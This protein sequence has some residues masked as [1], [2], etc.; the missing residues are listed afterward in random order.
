MAVPGAFGIYHRK[1]AIFAN[2]QTT[3]L[4]AVRA[5]GGAQFLETFLEVIPSFFAFAKRAT[6]GAK[7]QQDMAVIAADAQGKRFFGQLFGIAHE[8]FLNVVLDALHASGA[9]RSGNFDFASFA[10]LPDFQLEGFTGLSASD[11]V[12][13]LTRRIELDTIE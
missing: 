3:H 1:W 5:A 10:V 12:A 9:S 8:V 11:Q 2:P 4:G 13:Q 6:V 7:A